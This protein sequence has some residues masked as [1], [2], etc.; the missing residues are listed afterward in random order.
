ML[1]IEWNNC[2]LL[3]FSFKF[4]CMAIKY[5]KVGLMCAKFNTIKLHFGN[6]NIHTKEMKTQLRIIFNFLWLICSIWLPR[7]ILMFSCL[8]WDFGTENHN[9]VRKLWPSSPSQSST[10][11]NIVIRLKNIQIVSWRLANF[12]KIF[13]TIINTNLKVWNQVKSQTSLASY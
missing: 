8:Q 3:N 13:W 2:A 6:G 4:N 10:R 9:F 11:Q 5:N 12:V 1:I 7:L